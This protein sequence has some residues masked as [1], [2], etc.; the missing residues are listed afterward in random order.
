M[1]IKEK[2]IKLLWGRAANRCSFAECRIKLSQDKK[3][4]TESFPLGEQ[5]HI[6]GKEEGSARSKS[7]LSIGERDSYHNLILLCPN[8]HTII[9]KNPEDYPIEKL[10]M[11][12]SQ[13]E[14][15][16]E[17]TLSESHNLKVEANDIIYTHLIDMT[18]E[19]CEF[20]NWEYWISA[21]YDPIHRIEIDTRNMYKAIW[22]G[23]L[24]ELE[25]AMK[26]FSS[27]MNIMLNFYMKNAESREDCFYGDRSYKRRWH[28]EEIFEKLSERR[29]LWEEY[30]SEL[31]IEVVK[32]ANW[33]AD[34][35]RRDINP[36]FMAT[37][38]K[39]SL[40]GG[41]DNKLSFY[42]SIPEYSIDEKR[43]LIDSYEDKCI[44][45]KNKADL[46]DV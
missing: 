28:T 40:I 43:Q 7:I 8:H 4:A 30:L 35:V 39:F 46:I 12:K 18:V 13:H 42:T 3:T 9:D 22:P 45:F 32:A 25:S 16:V 11:M 17:I 26:L 37:D 34:L 19:D 31:I 20:H 14:Y 2:D 41:P 5:A 44:D 10:H 38:G 21:L 24:K 23:T 27:I 6:V 1:T 29:N 36:L 15:W 33:V